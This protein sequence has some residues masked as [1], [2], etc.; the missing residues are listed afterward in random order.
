M[1]SG[2]DVEV[3]DWLVTLHVKRHCNEIVEPKFG[4]QAPPCPINLGCGRGRASCV[5]TES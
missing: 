3:L 4:S 1:M 5:I 2:H